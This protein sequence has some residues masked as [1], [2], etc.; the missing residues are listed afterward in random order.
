MRI[1]FLSVSGEMG[2]SEVSLLT[3]VRGL[4]LHRPQWTRHVVVPREGP[5]ARDARASGAVV[6]VLPLPPALARLGEVGASGTMPRRAV[7]MLAAA[8][9]LP[10]YR[11]RLAALL[12][13]ISPD[14]VHTNG[15]KLH[16]LGA[17]AAPPGAALVWH[18]H[19]YVSSRPVSRTLLRRAVPRCAAIAANSRSV[20][21]DLA[22]VTR[23]SVPVRVIYNAVDLDECSPAGPAVDL[24]ALA[25]LAPAAPD[26]VR[27]GLV[28]TFGRWKGHETFLRAMAMLP[29]D[30]RIRG[31]VVGGPL[32][33]TAGSQHSRAELTAM[34]RALD[35]DDRVAFTGFVDRPARALRALDVVVHASTQPEPF[36]LVIAEAMACGR[37]VVMS[38]NAAAAEIARDGVDVLTHRPGDPADLARAMLACASDAGLRA[39]LG[40][41]ARRTAEAHFDVGAFVEAFEALY[42]GSLNVEAA[43]HGVSRH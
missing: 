28:A 27:V 21:D 11:R 14:V 23:G 17:R 2:G 35:V 32:Y 5:L 20:A 9:T 16:V 18:I 31:Y 13:G 8:G 3:L 10:S 12:A 39:R 6:H 41:S 29:R 4:G 37:A 25:G 19:E 22:S 42:A 26:I 33:D 38:A 36:G 1:A 40:A 24:D 7:R 43:A 15:F 34:A 30:A